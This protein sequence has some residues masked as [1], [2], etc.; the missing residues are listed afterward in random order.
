MTQMFINWWMTKQHMVCPCGNRELRTDSCSNM[1]ES[2]SMILSEKDTKC[3]MRPRICCSR[4]DGSVGTSIRS[5]LT[6]GWNQSGGKWLPGDFL[7]W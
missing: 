4:K 7:W 3:C 6:S 2:Q 5:V 1:D